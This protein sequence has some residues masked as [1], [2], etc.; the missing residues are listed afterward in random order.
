[1]DWV[2]CTDIFIV[3]ING[4]H[5]LAIFNVGYPSRLK[6]NQE[7]INGDLNCK[8]IQMKFAVYRASLN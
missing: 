3:I 4:Q 8:I 1:M 2:F 6:L 7:P 5:S